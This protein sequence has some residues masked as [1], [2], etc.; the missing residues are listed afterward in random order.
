MNAMD[1]HSSS[2]ALGAACAVLLATLIAVPA[3]AQ[4][5]Q[6]D[7][8][9]SFQAAF[10]A[11]GWDP[12]EEELAATLTRWLDEFVVGVVKAAKRDDVPGVIAQADD[13]ANH[14][15]ALFIGLGTDVHL[16]E[17]RDELP[18]LDIQQ[19]AR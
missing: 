6:S 8:G 15:R 1:L 5:P 9:A 7:V 19:D 18:C 14:R 3:S 16:G 4:S 11:S 10:A 12:T 17:V 13:G 2:G